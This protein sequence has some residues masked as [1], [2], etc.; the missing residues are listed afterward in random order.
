MGG[1]VGRIGPTGP[2]GLTTTTGTGA[3]AGAGAGIGWAPA[4]A[5]LGTGKPVDGLPS[6]AAAMVRATAAFTSGETALPT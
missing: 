2:S 4:I 6:S 5:L 1:T 3:G